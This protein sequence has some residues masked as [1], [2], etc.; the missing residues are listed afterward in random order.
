MLPRYQ[1]ICALV[2]V[3]LMAA[4]A[5]AQDP[6]AIVRDGEVRAAIVVQPDSSEQLLEAVEEMRRLIERAS[7]ASLQVAEAPP[8]G[9][10]AIHV[11]RT[12]AVQSLAID[13]GDLDGDGFVIEFPVANSI[14]ILGPTDWGTEFGIYE[15]LE[16]YVGARWLMPGP[17][18]T[19]VPDRATIEVPRE[20]VRQEPAFFSRK[21]FGLKHEAQQLWARRNRLHSRVEFHH[22][23]YKLFPH[24]DVEEHP[25]F[26][27]IRD[28]ERYF[29]PP[30][31]HHTRWQPCFTAPGIVETA[32]QRIIE[33]FNEHPEAQSYS[34]G[35]TDSSGHC[36]CERCRA[37]DP[38]REN[39]L[40]REHLSDRYFT[41][42]NAVVER[43]LEVHPDKFFGCLAYSEI[44]E[45]PDRVQVHRRIIPYVTYDRMK[46]I[47][48]DIRREGQD[49]TRRWAEASPRVG[50]YDY[51]Y[52]SIYCVPRVYFH[53]MAEYYRFGHDHGVRALT[54][55]A[56]PNFGEGP[57]LYVSLKLQ[58]D[59]T[60]DVD[61]LLEQWYRLAVGEDAAPYLQRYYHHWED[62]W[63]RRILES[64]WFRERGQYLP[65]YS[66][67][68]LQDVAPEEVAQC[69]E[70][71]E[72]AVEATETAGQRART[73]L[74]LRA[75]EYY[76]ASVIAYPR[77]G[78]APRPASEAEALEHI[79]RSLRRTQMAQKRLRLAL[80]D[81]PGHPFL[82]FGTSID[83]Y[84][85]VAGR[86]WGA[87]T[88]WAVFD[89]ALR[90][91]AVRERIEALAEAG[92]PAPLTAH[93]RAMLLAARPGQSLLANSSF[94]EGEGAQAEG[95]SY[96]LQ[97][98]VGS[99]TRTDEMAFTGER[100]VRCDAVQ[101]GGPHQSVA[102]EPGYYALVCRLFVP[103]DVEL[104]GHCILSLRALDAD[105]H[106]LPGGA[107][108][109]LTPVQGRWQAVAAVADLRE[110]ANATS[111]RAGVWARDCAPDDRIYI[112]DVA[113]MRLPD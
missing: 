90:S 25:E 18:G 32:A 7:G 64:G 92:E 13:L 28:G 14:V 95:W 44:F 23:L 79:D 29:P 20:P 113:L 5:A 109:E 1:A 60:Q 19:Y 94:E 82:H 97:D 76:E 85:A 31:T 86:D 50:W 105:G 49:L 91:D 45:P 11:G 52:G 8:E 58:W 22:Q 106:N 17:D 33:Y 41:W 4:P 111:V 36:E 88:L 51:I 55:E 72:A 12:P 104:Q 6:L 62:F 63:T 3:G 47:H 77:E 101:Y 103:E 48:P 80:E 70:W 46:W 34:L 2:A 98:G 30:D 43:V 83:R 84:E 69:R 87:T 27:P 37:L 108:V 100:S 75:F 26:F 61:A 65:F 38:G 57:K 110:V 78:A 102:F 74:L 96:W 73:E 59:P 66:P 42:A 40:G 112:D 10:A 24:S 99:L 68:Y 16:R 107:T 53:Q 9:M 81:F 67:A 93:A 56:Y 35:V 39:V 89:W 15:F 54:A 71:L 21:Y